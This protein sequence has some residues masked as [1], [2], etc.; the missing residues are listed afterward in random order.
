MSLRQTAKN[1]K[2]AEDLHA[3]SFF[4]GI[5]FRVVYVILCI[6]GEIHMS[7][8]PKDFYGVVQQLPTSMKVPGMKVEKA[9]TQ[10][11]P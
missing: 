3:R 6:R 10:Q 8:F 9:S 5:L 7:K 1:Y 2:I 11:I 4:P